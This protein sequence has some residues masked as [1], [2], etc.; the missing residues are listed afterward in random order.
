MLLETES[1]N[2]VNN[3]S[4]NKKKIAKE[5]TKL[6]YTRIDKEFIVSNMYIL[7]TVSW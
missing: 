1:L 4:D 7:V 6:V 3:N 5:E 2:K